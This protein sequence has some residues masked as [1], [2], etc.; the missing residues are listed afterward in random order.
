LS[1]LRYEGALAAMPDDVRLAIVRRS[2]GDV[3]KALEAVAPLARDVRARGDEA[4]RAITKRFDGVDLA[5]F[6]VPRADV[7]AALARVDPAFGAALEAAA[8]NIRVFHEAQRRPDLE[9][10]VAPGVRAGRRYVPLAK[11]GCY[12]PGGRAAYPSTVLMTVLP[13]KVAGVGEIVLA[14]PPRADGAIPDATLAAA[15]VAGADR[16]FALGGAQAVFALAYGTASVPRVDKIVG[17]GNAYVAAA[18]ALVAGEVAIDAPAGP[19][20]VLV[21]ADA[22]ADADAVAWDLLA[23]AEHDPAASAVLV[24]TDAP[25]LARAR[26]ALERALATTP[27]AAIAREALAA[28]GALLLARDLDEAVAFAEAFAPEHLSIQTAAPRAVLARL[29]TYG[30]AFLGPY[31]PVAFGD[32]ASGPNHVLPTAGLA[33]SFSGLSVD[34]FLRRPTHQEVDREGFRTL[35]PTVATLARAEGL[36]AHAASVEARRP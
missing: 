8:R 34:D 24:A 15:A 31:S 5:R 7:E 6:E 10:E 26:T 12:A 18:K 28:R 20:E 19:S 14:T 4:L 22:T 25:L 3:A 21:V 23:Q 32:Y 13:A 35:A 29:R 30:S 9:V 2:A 16:V 27:R 17:P 11:V 33:R 36:H 1:L